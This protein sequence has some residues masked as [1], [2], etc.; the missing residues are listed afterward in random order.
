MLVSKFYNY[1]DI[2]TLDFT[3]LPPFQFSLQRIFIRSLKQRVE[4]YPLNHKLN[5]NKIIP[6]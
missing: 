6:N 3:G 2:N 5:L 4:S 1:D